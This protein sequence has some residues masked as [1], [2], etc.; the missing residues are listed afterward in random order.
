MQ[1]FRPGWLPAWLLL[2]APLIGCGQKGPLYLPKPSAQPTVS[3]QPSAQ[4]TVS[5]QPSSATPP[6]RTA[7]SKQP[8]PAEP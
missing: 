8:P 1:R 2:I 5:E 3:E 4:P 7:I 6:T